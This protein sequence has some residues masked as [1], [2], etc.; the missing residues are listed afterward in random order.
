MERIQKTSNSET[1]PFIDHVQYFGVVFDKM[2]TWSL[3]TDMIKEKAC[4][5]ITRVYSSLKSE[6][7]KVNIKLT[8]YKK[9]SIKTYTCTP[10]LMSI[11]I[12]TCIY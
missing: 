1:F 11:T 7:L 2:I 12:S 8:L 10:V 4:R 3:G 5:T 9:W 6:Q